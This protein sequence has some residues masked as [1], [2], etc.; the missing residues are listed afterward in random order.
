MALAIINT[1]FPTFFFFYLK[2]SKKSL[3]YAHFNFYNKRLKDHGSI[4]TFFFI[5][6]FKHDAN[7]SILT[8]FRI[9]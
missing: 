1:F 9:K 5:H 3:A 6:I 8:V 7:L 2:Q 4:K